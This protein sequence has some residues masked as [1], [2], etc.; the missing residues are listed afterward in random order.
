METQTPQLALLDLMFKEADGIELMEY[1]FQFAEIP[2]IF[3]SYYRQEHAIVTAFEK[4]AYDYIP[5]P[6]SP[7][8]LLARIR[9]SLRQRHR[10]AGHPQP[11]QHYA[12][13]D[14]RIDYDSREVTIAGIPVHLTP[15]EYRLLQELS[16]QSGLVLTGDTIMARVWGPGTT[17]DHRTLRVAVMTLRRKLGDPAD[18]PVYIHTK[19]GV[20]YRM[21][22]SQ[23]PPEQSILR[24]DQA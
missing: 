14:L 22:K 19:P 16:L 24:G 8:E 2:V 23:R 20:G 7:A 18:D 21:P 12:W 11:G 6:F 4:G 3:L 17:G 5:K 13:K 1:I 10:H 15:T 9:A